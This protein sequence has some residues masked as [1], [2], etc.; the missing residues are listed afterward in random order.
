MSAELVPA[1]GATAIPGT[2]G[3]AGWGDIVLRRWDEEGAVRLVVALVV[4]LVVL[5]VVHPI[6]PVTMICSTPRQAKTAH[7][8]RLDLGSPASFCRASNS[9]P[10]P[11]ST[12]ASRADAA[13]KSRSRRCC[14]E[15]P[16]SASL[17]SALPSRSS[18]APSTSGSPRSTS[19]SPPPEAS[20]VT[21]S[22]TAALD[23]SQPV[24]LLYARSRASVRSP[25]RT[26]SASFSA[27]SCS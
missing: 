5:I 16:L 6:A 21:T 7:P 26:R 8:L 13:S 11:L 20:A 12:T 2:T 10:A 23:E 1:V 22:S 27:L 3:K 15:W 19:S 9:E 4:G 17:P 14:A 25:M 24:A 18:T